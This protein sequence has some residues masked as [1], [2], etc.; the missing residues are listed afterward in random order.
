MTAEVPEHS[1]ITSSGNSLANAVRLNVGGNDWGFARINFGGYLLIGGDNYM[2]IDAG[3]EFGWS[4][5]GQSQAY[6]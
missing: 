4:T 2:P 3:V 1:A 6:S 5:D